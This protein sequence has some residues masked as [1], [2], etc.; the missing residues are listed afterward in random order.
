MIYSLCIDDVHYHQYQVRSILSRIKYIHGKIMVIGRAIRRFSN[1]C[2]NGSVSISYLISEI[3][4]L[5]YFL[6]ISFT[7]CVVWNLESL[8]RS[9]TVNRINKSHFLRM[10]NCIQQGR[11][12]PEIKFEIGEMLHIFCPALLHGCYNLVSSSVSEVRL[13]TW[14][15]FA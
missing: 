4:F 12:K 15:Y 9:L 14:E 3:Y 5:S 1:L 6:S 13:L 11:F 8:W 10:K 2:M 7:S